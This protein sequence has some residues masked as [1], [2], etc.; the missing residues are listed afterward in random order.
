[1]PGARR[2]IKLAYIEKRIQCPHCRGELTIGTVMDKI[3]LS[4]RACPKCHNEFVIDNDVP[5][6]LGAEKKPSESVQASRTHK[7]TKSR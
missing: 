3:L 4:R 6:K 7:R 2:Q 5:K 1:M